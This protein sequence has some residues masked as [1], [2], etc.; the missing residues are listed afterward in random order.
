MDIDSEMKSVTPQ[1]EDKQ[2]KAESS[3]EPRKATSPV[4][5]FKSST[6]TPGPLS[7]RRS[8]RSFGGNGTDSSESENLE[9]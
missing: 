8:D 1:E 5:R 4:E 9:I 6:P 2:L 3:S 7:E